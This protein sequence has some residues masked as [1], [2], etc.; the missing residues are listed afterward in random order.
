M[1]RVRRCGRRVTPLSGTRCRWPTLLLFLPSTH[2]NMIP[3]PTFHTARLVFAAANGDKGDFEAIKLLYDDPLTQAYACGS[4]PL[5]AIQAFGIRLVI[6]LTFRTG[7]FPRRFV[8]STPSW[9]G[10]PC[11]RADSLYSPCAHCLMNN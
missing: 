1:Q 6:F 2:S 7:Q 9:R 4:P 5:Y 8:K 3:T 10:P 11:W